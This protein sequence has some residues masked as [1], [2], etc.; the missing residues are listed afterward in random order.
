LPALPKPLEERSW[1]PVRAQFFVK[2]REEGAGKQRSGESGYWVF[3]H[4]YDQ[5]DDTS[6][7]STRNECDASSIVEAGSL[8]SGVIAGIVSANPRRIP[9]VDVYLAH[10]I[11]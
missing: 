1:I 10:V 4:R 9:G 3:D 11:S 8:C 6:R 5:R 7:R 2:Q